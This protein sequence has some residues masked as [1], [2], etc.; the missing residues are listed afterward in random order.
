MD[1]HIAVLSVISGS[2]KVILFTQK[3]IVTK[4]INVLA[5]IVDMFGEAFSVQQ[6]MFGW[7]GIFGMERSLWKVSDYV[8]FVYS[9][10]RSFEDTMYF[11]K[12][13]LNNKVDNSY[14]V[15]MLCVDEFSFAEKLPTVAENVY[16]EKYI[17]IG[18]VYDHRNEH[19]L[20]LDDTNLQQRFSLFYDSRFKDQSFREK[21]ECMVNSC[22]EMGSIE[23]IT[24]KFWRRGE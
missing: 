14:G 7:K 1:Q 15:V 10:D 24:W 9:N 13:R 20:F 12:E 4:Q 6:V 8:E 19:T 23:D 11:L 5:Q 3:F 17:S 22:L 21:F 16:I 18:V 2:T